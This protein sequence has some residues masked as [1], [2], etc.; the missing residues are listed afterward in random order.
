VNIRLLFAG[1]EGTESRG[2]RVEGRAWYALSG[3]L[4][5]LAPIWSGPLCVGLCL[6]SHR[7]NRWFW[8]LPS[9]FGPSLQLQRPICGHFLLTVCDNVL[10]HVITHARP[11]DQ[12]SA[13]VTAVACVSCRPDRYD[14]TSVLMLSIQETALLKVMLRAVPI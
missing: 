1:L 9:V 4:H 13:W 3:G 10:L 6:R 12:K 8:R 7:T 14:R 5:V 11:S 2:W